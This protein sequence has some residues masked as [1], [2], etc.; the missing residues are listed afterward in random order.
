MD[1]LLSHLKAIIIVPLPRPLSS[2][3]DASTSLPG[4]KIVEI[5]DVEIHDVEIH[6]VEI[7]DVK[8]QTVS[9]KPKLLVL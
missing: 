8:I 4:P 5:H 6:D 1:M 2:T 7:H 9:V 3:R